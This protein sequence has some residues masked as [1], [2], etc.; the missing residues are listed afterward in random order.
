MIISLLVIQT[1]S[2]RYHCRVVLYQ[3]L[4]TLLV[5]KKTES[6]IH[7]VNS[8]SLLQSYILHSLPHPQCMWW[9]QP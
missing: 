1:A 4:V 3:P 5:L 9:I 6:F 2:D 7:T 8:L